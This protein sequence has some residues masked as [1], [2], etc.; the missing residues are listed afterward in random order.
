M[1]CSISKKFIALAC[2]CGYS[3][4]TPIYAAESNCTVL[5]GQNTHIT[6]DDL[7]KYID[8][9][10]Y[11][12]SNTPGLII[13]IVAGNETAMI[14]CG[15]TVKGNH[16]R[17]SA[18]TIWAIGSV[19]KVITSTIL[20]EMAQENIVSLTDTVQKYLPRHVKIARYQTREVTLLDLATHTSGLMN[21]IID[22]DE[23]D[24]QNQKS[25]NTQTAYNWIN[26]NSL[27]HM[28]GTF[29]MY[30]NFA[31]GLLGHALAHAENMSYEQLLQK[32]ISKR[33]DMHDTT[34]K[35]TAEQ[36][37]REAKS[38]WMNGDEI[39][40]DWPFDFDAASGGIY[41]SGADMMRFL[42]YHLDMSKP[43]PA[44]NAKIINHATYVYQNDVINPIEFKYNGMALGWHVEYPNQ[45]MPLILQKNGWVDGFTT[46]V[47]L[48]PTEKIGIFSISNKPYLNIDG[49]LRN[50]MGLILHSRR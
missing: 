40:H 38:Y 25:Y 41:S 28:P 7:A 31:F 11:Q 24:Y 45:D 26:K 35:L 29:Y 47:M 27:H 13:G 34:T 1:L 46:W 37:K 49:D 19:S 18:D 10:I 20:A 30:S 42:Q 14:S 48:M 5:S 36:I 12:Q 44:L 50:I 43:D 39:K 17:P 21:S 22:E 32:Y 9:M 3:I 23:N 15:E 4:A 8:V 2:L 6:V 33:L 16:Q